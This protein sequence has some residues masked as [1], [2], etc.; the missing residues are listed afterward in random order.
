MIRNLNV[1]PHALVDVISIPSRD[2]KLK[3]MK[4]SNGKIVMDIFVY[5]RMTKLVRLFS[6]K[7]S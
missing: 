1:K 7:A 3:S 5:Q 6:V 2:I 4:S